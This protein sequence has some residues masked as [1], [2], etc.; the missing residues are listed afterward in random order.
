MKN[1]RFLAVLIVNVLMLNCNSDPG[2]LFTSANS[3]GGSSSKSTTNSS[4][5]IGGYSSSS[6]CTPKITCQSVGAECGVI[7]DDGCG[8][9]VNCGDNCTPPL[10]CGGGGSQFKCGCTGQ[11]CLAQEKNCGVIDDGCGTPIDCGKCSDLDGLDGFACTNN[12]CTCVPKT[13]CSDSECG[14]ITDDCKN[15]IDCGD[16]DPNKGEAPCGTAKYDDNGAP[17]PLSSNMCGGGCLAMTELESG[18]LCATLYPNEPTHAHYWWC[19]PYVPN[20]GSSNPTPIAGTCFSST[21]LMIVEH[22]GIIGRGWC[23]ANGL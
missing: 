18:F 10:F 5:G 14:I 11:S 23:C 20:I 17:L 3:T 15:N 7:E 13:T 6:G 8:R 16:C 22:N 21:P 1:C 9:I 2:L 12:V 19:T 4:S